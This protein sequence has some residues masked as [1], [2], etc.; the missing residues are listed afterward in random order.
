MLV[1]RTPRRTVSPLTEL[2]VLGQTADALDVLIRLGQLESAIVDAG[3]GDSVERAF[4]AAMRAAARRWLGA[5]A[6]SPIQELAALP[7]PARVELT[8]PEGYAWYALN[9]E[10]YVEAAER[11]YRE[12][13]PLRVGILGIRSIG[14]SLS[15]VVAA[16]LEQ[17]GCSVQSWTVRP[18]GHPFDRR[19][20]LTR[21]LARDLTPVGEFAVVDEGPGLSGSSMTSVAEALS[22]LGVADER[23]SLF[24]SWVPDGSGFKSEK[25]RLRWPR[26]RKYCSAPAAPPAGAVDLS[27][28]R[29]RDH[30]LAGEQEWPAVQPQHE[31]VKYLSEGRLFRFAGLGAFGS[32]KLERAAVLYEGGFGPRPVDLRNGFLS[33]E[34]VPVRAAVRAPHNLLETVAR[35]LC[36]LRDRFPAPRGASFDELAEMIQVNAGVPR[37]SLET[38]RAAAEDAPAVAIDGRLFPHEW[39]ETAAGYIKTDA[40]DHHDDHFLPG[41]QPIAW[42]VAAAA[43]ESGGEDF[44]VERCRPGPSLPFFRLAYLAFRLGYSGLAAEALAGTPDGARFERAARRYAALIERTCGPQS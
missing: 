25:A 17:L 33:M 37:A 32:P 9:P 21:E 24:P 28:G 39:L 34:F 36:F 2:Q 6:L 29:W 12:R 35:Y 5:E 41:C 20:N 42:D 13:Q 23:I 31:R 16:R 27:A 44:L 18:T 15:A 11:Y 4:R 14:T 7:L 26:H 38:W 3:C 22:G 10:S 40:L 1:Y 8:T 30:F 19:L 43:V